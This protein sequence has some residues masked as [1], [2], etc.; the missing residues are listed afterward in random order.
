[1]WCRV[2]LVQVIWWQVFSDPPNLPTGTER[3]QRTKER[4]VSFKSGNNYCEKMNKTME[5]LRH[6]FLSHLYS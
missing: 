1:M 3:M 4:I 2:V 5:R 6:F